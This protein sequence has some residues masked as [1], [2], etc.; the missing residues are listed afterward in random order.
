MLI[1]N[2]FAVRLFYFIEHKLRGVMRNLF[3]IHSL[4]L[5]IFVN[6][7]RQSKEKSLDLAKIEVAIYYLKII[8]TIRCIYLGGLFVLVSL[9]F[10]IHGFMFIHVA[11]F[12]YVP[13]S[14]ETKALVILLLGICYLMAPLGIYI[15]CASQRRWMKF[16]RSGE[17]VQKVIK[18]DS[19]DRNE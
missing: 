6:F 10:M 3:S 15:Y 19:E 12:Y 8:K 14:R 17:L 4:L 5:H 7:I 9:I 13:W 18:N 1:D 16:S 2:I 11:F